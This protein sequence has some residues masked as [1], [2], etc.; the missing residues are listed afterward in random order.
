M[1][2]ADGPLPRT[3]AEQ[4]AAG[5]GPFAVERGETVIN[6]VGC[7]EAVAAPRAMVEFV[8]EGG[9]FALGERRQVGALGQVLAEEAIG[10]LIGPALPRMMGQG[11]VDGGAQ[12]SLQGLVHMELGAVVRGERANAMGLIAEQS[13]GAF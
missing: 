1:T 2:A 9:A 11:E 5:S 8:G 13:D 6:F 7:E 3:G 10:V 12:T 4:L